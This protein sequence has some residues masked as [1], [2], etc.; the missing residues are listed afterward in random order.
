[1][2]INQ[3]AYQTYALVIELWSQIGKKIRSKKI[4]GHA[5]EELECFQSQSFPSLF[6]L[7]ARL[8]VRPSVC[9]SVCLSVCPT[10]SVAA[11]LATCLSVCLSV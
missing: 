3:I 11:C 2:P 5:N 10:V 9:L 1:M 4:P 8:S 6:I 7:S